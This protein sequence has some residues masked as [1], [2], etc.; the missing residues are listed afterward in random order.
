[1]L[2]T[3]D[4]LSDPATWIAALRDTA[5]KNDAAYQAEGHGDDPQGFIYGIYFP[6]SSA[7]KYAS[8]GPD[9]T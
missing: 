4:D 2:G 9:E 5:K 7:C 3:D 8:I 6:P 1:M